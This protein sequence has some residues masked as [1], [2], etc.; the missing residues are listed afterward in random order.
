VTW[1]G[2]TT[3][4]T[5]PERGRDRTQVAPLGGSLLVAA[6]GGRDNHGKNQRLD[7]TQSP[8]MWPSRSWADGPHGSCK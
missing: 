2:Q 4:K 8:T 6:C 7:S 1:E 5:P 3:L